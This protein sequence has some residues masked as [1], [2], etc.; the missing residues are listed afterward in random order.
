M[1]R[2]LVAISLAILGCDRGE[3]A[4]PPPSPPDL[5][6]VSA[7][8][9]PRRLL[10]Y[11][12]PKGAKQGLEVA[13]DLDLEAGE[14]G[15]P[16]PTL[17]ITM[18]LAVEDVLPDARMK[19]HVTIV[20]ATA[21]DRAESKV[22]ASAL[23][24]PLDA[25]KGIAISGLLSPNGRLGSVAVEGG[26][27]LPESVA[28]QLASLTASFEQTMMPLPDVPVGVGAVWRNSRTIEQN[29]LKLT[30]VNSVTLTAL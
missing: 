25:M 11:H 15:G 3:R 23:S 19:L 22:P 17:A 13:I 24:G 30:A 10:R 20:D 2:A 8:D 4:A 28:A 27:Q 18:L 29:S 6:M 26:K 9:E 12:L 14:V 16:L 7:G 5:Q 21:H 1:K